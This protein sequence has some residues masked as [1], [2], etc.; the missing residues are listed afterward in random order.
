M[1][2]PNSLI[3]MAA[4]LLMGSLASSPGWSSRVFSDHVIGTITAT[5]I[6]DEIEI[7]GHVY[8]IKHGSQAAQ[9][10]HGFS[11][12]QKVE[13]VLDGPPDSASSGVL[14]IRLQSGS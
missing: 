7:D 1:K 9:D 8:H 10:L 6:V 14:N 5:P 11:E 12:G 3:L 2:R 13:I 4:I